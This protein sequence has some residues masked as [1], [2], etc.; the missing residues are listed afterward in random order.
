MRIVIATA[1]FDRSSG[2]EAVWTHG[3]ASHLTKAGHDVL[4]VT[5]TLTEA[6]VAYPVHRVAK[7]W[8]PLR[9]AD[10]YQ[11]A[12]SALAPDAVYDCG[13]TTL[14]A[15]SIPM[16]APPFTASSSWWPRSR[17]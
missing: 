10:L 9:R 3:F 16:Q 2:G 11:A 17:G 8:S 12:I 15:S 13:L 14:L 1:N 5:T 7:T 6:H 4:I